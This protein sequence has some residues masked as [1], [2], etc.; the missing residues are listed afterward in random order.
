MES[1]NRVVISK[2][3]VK[4]DKHGIKTATVGITRVIEDGDK[5]T[6]DIE[7]AIASMAANKKMQKLSLTEEVG[8]R[9]LVFFSAPGIDKP[10]EMIAGATLGRFTLRREEAEINEALVIYFEFTMQLDHARQWVLP[11]IGDDVM[12]VVEDMQESFFGS[13]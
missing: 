7:D 10:S 1:A 4:K 8:A 12:L 3:K 5:F 9:N 6:P 11:S 13:N 2:I